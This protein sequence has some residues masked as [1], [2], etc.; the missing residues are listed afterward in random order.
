MEALSRLI[1]E[2]CSYLDTERNL[3]PHT[4]EA[5][6]RDLDQLAA[7]VLREKGE[8]ATAADVDHLLLRRYL[9]LLGD[10]EFF[11]VSSALR[12]HHKEPG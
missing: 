8:A 10:T 5:Y 6:R 2:F 12:G 3:S 4:L 7:F 9:A 1:T 11:Q